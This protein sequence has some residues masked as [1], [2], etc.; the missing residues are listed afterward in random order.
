MSLWRGETDIGWLE[1]LD[2][3]NSVASLRFLA[4]PTDVAGGLFPRDDGGVS[5]AAADQLRAYLGG[6]LRAFDLPLAPIGSAFR[7]AVW[8]ALLGLHYGETV[9]YGELARRLGMPG[10]A[11]AVGLACN[12][13]PLPIFIPCHRVVGAN[14]SLVGYSG[15]LEIKR[16]LLE[17]EGGV[18]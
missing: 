17:L 1:I 14:G 16:K 3:G 8:S 12:R 2:D 9:S 5:R 6:S 13:N 10:S 7:L 11:R 18:A 4:A 15:G